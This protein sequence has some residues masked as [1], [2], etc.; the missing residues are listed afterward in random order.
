MQV[1]QEQLQR[2]DG[3][4]CISIFLIKKKL[5]VVFDCSSSNRGKSLNA[6][7]LHGP[8]FEANPSTSTGR[9][10]SFRFLWWPKGD[11][12]KPLEVYQMN[13][14]LFSALS[15]PSIANF[16]LQ[17]TGNSDK[18]SMEVLETMKHS[19]YVDDCLSVTSVRQ[20][21]KLTKDLREPCAKE[22]YLWMTWTKQR[23]QSFAM[24]NSITLTQ[25]LLYLHTQTGSD[26]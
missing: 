18:Y 17:Q 10:L 22:A 16:A 26:C 12:T 11:V 14:H 21:I 13:V 8:D 4:V 19:F 6:E 1:P 3:Q 9:L 20:A 2:N 5:R 15:S 7:L 25:N 24:N 23:S